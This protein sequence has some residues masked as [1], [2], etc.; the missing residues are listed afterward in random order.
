MSPCGLNLKLMSYNCQSHPDT[1]RQSPICDGLSS[2]TQLIF[3]P[4]KETHITK[5]EETPLQRLVFAPL[6]MTFV[7]GRNGRTP[8][9]QREIT[10][11]SFF[12]R[13]F[14]YVN[15]SMQRIA[16]QEIRSGIQAVLAFP[17]SVDLHLAALISVGIPL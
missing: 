11:A 5:K 8:L 3:A 2:Q 6:C 12:W 17:V 14:Y 10:A 15:M 1:N 9:P 13:K 4:L 7:P 16:G